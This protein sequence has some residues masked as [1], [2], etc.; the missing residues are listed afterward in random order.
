M[1]DS[2]MLD[3][4]RARDRAFCE[5]HMHGDNLS[6]CIL[7]RMVQGMYPT[8]AILR[9]LTAY[10]P[11]LSGALAGAAAGYG[12]VRVMDYM[13]QHGID[14]HLVHLECTLLEYAARASNVA[15]VK[16]LLEQGAVA[17]ER[18]KDSVWGINRE[19]YDVLLLSSR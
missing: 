17:T 6:A 16:Y 4:L 18:A 7:H 15:M 3:F 11:P 13:L 8:S 19:C 14:V 2:E 12:G 10:R 1:G 9:F 5:Q